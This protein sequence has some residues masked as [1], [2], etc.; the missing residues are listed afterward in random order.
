MIAPG[1]RGEGSPAPAEIRARHLPDDLLAACIH[2]GLCLPTCPTYALTGNEASSPRGRIALMAAVAA[3]GL[4][5]TRTFRYE[6]GFCLDCRA[7]ET[8]CPA[9]VQYGRLV[10]GARALVEELAP[11]RTRRALLRL[12]LGSPGRLDVMAA[13]LRPWSRSSARRAVREMLRRLAPGLAEREEL[14]PPLERPSRLPRRI[15]AAGAW[16][17][18]GPA[19]DSGR[20]VRVGMLEGCV[21]RHI[22]P[23]VNADTAAVLARN[24]IEVVV[25]PGQGCCGSLHA[26]SGDLAGARE[27]ARRNLRAFEPLEELDA[28]VVNAAG[29]GSLLKHVDRAFEDGDPDRVR[30]RAFAE[31]VRDAMEYLVRRGWSTPAGTID[32]RVTY[33]DPCHLV[34]GQGIQDAPRDILG[35][36]PGVELVP[37]EESTWCCGSAGVYNLTHPVAAQQLLDRKLRHVAA[38]GASILA[39]ANPGCF[40]QL[41]AGLEQRGMK[42]ELAHPL[43]LLARAYRVGGAAYASRQSSSTCPSAPSPS[44]PSSSGAS[45]R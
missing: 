18:Q 24:G 15:P 19:G 8:A 25:P 13:I 31:R 16:A 9:G 40:V 11:S 38:T 36:I 26:H 17:D 21:Q 33:H 23:E 45:S 42:V 27:L 41:A 7:C 35:S 43:S 6:M 29:C 20:V 4:D 1:P 39:T 14:L 32:A 2:C 28:I 10:E 30:A 34:H 37:L 44:A 5:L 3:G 12:A 22:L